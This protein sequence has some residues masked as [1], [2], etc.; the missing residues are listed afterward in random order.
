MSTK[1]EGFTP[2]PWTAEEIG[3]TTRAVRIVGKHA[4]RIMV[5]GGPAIAYLPEG[6]VDIQEANAAL[7]ADAPRLYAENQRLREAAS[8]LIQAHDNLYPEG[9]MLGVFVTQL[10]AALTG[11]DA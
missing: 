6:R 5:P 3:A 11:P 8:S 1:H 4:R 10:E 7:M 9:S 2:G